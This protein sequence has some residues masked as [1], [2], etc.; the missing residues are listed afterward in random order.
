M[1][2]IKTNN[3][4]RDPELW[5]LAQKRAGFKK[6]L[7]TYLIVNIFLW[8]IWYFTRDNHSEDGRLPWPVW[9]TFG[10]GIAIVLQYINVYINH[11]NNSVEKEYQ[12]LKNKN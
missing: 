5:E 1:E 8:G 3:A 2:T 6:H 7:A 11:K 12:K 4:G 10:W 9:G